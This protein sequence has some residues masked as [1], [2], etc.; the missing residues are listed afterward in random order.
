MGE[1]YY[2]VIEQRHLEKGACFGQA[3]CEPEIRLAGCRISGRMIMH[4]NN[5]VGGVNEGR[6]KDFPGMRYALVDAP[7]GDLF[8]LD[9]MMPG[10]EQNGSQRFLL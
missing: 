1:S 8:D 9:D 7:Q 5:A 4:H 3:A 10:I 6:L 2:N